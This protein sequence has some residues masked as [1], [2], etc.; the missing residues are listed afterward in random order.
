[1]LFRFNTSSVLLLVYLLTSTFA[2]DA[3]ARHPFQEKRTLLKLREDSKNVPVYMG[4][5][6][7]DQEFEILK[8]IRSDGL[9]KKNYDEALAKLKMRAYE[10]HADA[11]VD[12]TCEKVGHSVAASCYGHAIKW[13]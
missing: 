4:N 1:M 12:V 8:L 2:V 13:K 9:F 7:P 6:I 3:A 5:D 11:V 10:L